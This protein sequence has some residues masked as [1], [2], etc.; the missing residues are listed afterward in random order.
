MKYP[1]TGDSG[2]SCQAPLTSFIAEPAQALRQIC[3]LKYRTRLSAR[4][5]QFAAALLTIVILV[6]TTAVVSEIY[7]VGLEKLFVEVTLAI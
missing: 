7:T 6:S 4:Y 2:R 3:S 5:A 1:E